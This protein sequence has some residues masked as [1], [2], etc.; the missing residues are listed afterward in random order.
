VL[1]RRLSAELGLPPVV[2][3]A[4]VQRGVADADQG[5]AYLEPSVDQLL[6]PLLLRDM[7]KAAARIARA[8]HEGEEI[9][10]YGDY[11][12][13][14]LS[15]TA[16]MMQFL[17][18]LGCRPHVYVPNRAFEG[19]SFTEG[20]VAHVIKT[21]A[22]VVI[23]V[24][25]G[26]GSVAPVG[27]LAAAGVDVIIT[28]HHLPGGELPPAFA[29][30]NPRRHDCGY[31]FKSLA[32]VGVAF[33][34][35]CAVANRLSEGKRRSPEMMRFLGEAMAWVALGTLA[36][37]VPLQGENRILAARG[38][39]AIPVSTS[40]GLAALC[41]VA[42]VRRAE[43]STEDVTFRLAPRLNA[44]GR[45]GRADLSLALLTAV[46]EPT[47]RPL[48]EQ[49]DRLNNQRR[50]MDRELLAAVQAQLP[51][52]PADEPVVMH[53][54]RW[55]AGLLGV[56]ASRI[57]Q[58]HGRPAVLISGRNGE[59]CKGSCRS[60]PGFDLHAAL[61]ECSEHLQEHG[62]HAMAAGFS[63]RAAD[64]PAFR[65][66]FAGVWR[67]HLD[68]PAPAA[69][70]DYDGELPL[71]ALTLSL[72]EQLERLAPFGEGNPRPVLGA[73]AVT[74]LDARRM[75]GDGTHLQAQLAQGATSLRAVA[76]GRGDLADELP[77]GAV[78]DVLFTPKINRFRGRANVELELVDLRLAAQPALPPVHPAE[79][80][81][82]RPSESEA[83]G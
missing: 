53:D 50:Q 61:A 62:G 51:L 82:Q 54:D 65:R 5:R 73:T 46:D 1:V 11:D 44:A 30:V 70:L 26:I 48:A 59:P 67:R 31:P 35:A 49:L 79:P 8:V 69:A 74:L 22:R 81:I 47:A 21:G 15:S 71:A 40:P 24:D 83:A 32:G 23:S 45:L 72:V 64:V 20:G 28:D 63:V 18:Y 14:G 75:G 27:E 4:L 37:M 13:D 10:V 29:V 58:Q 25:N 76:F 34:V 66:A 12:V 7:D 36:D 39:R 33:K 19:Y 9:L 3:A 52:Q 42:E 41:A 16:L 55:P 57:A 56:A 60:V 43:F 2:A 77:R 17:R 68:R 78:A 6:D 38:L 80:L